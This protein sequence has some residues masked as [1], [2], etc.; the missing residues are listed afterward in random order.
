MSDEDRSKL[1]ENWESLKPWL[2]D[3]INVE[4]EQSG[5]NHS[6]SSGAFVDIDK[7]KAS[8]E[9]H[10]YLVS[11][12]SIFNLHALSMIDLRHKYKAADKNYD[13]GNV[14]DLT[15]ISC[16]NEKRHLVGNSLVLIPMVDHFNYADEGV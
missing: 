8:F 6:G 4:D 3:Q 15:V 5:D 1:D 11:I 16:T 13:S 14:K 10:W 12:R 2:C 7:I 9:Y